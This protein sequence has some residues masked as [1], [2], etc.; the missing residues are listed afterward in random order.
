MKILVIPATNSADGLNR[1]L[2][3]YAAKLLEGGLLS[4][5]LPSDNRVEIEFVD[6][7]DYEMPIY[8]VKREQADGVPLAGQRLFEKIGSA[9]AII[10]SFAEYNGSYTSAW[11]NIH[12][13]MSRIDM[14]IYQGRKVAMFAA[15]PGPRG[16]AGVLGGAIA[17]APFFGAELVGSLG[18]PT[19]HENVDAE[20]GE[21]SNSDL[22]AEFEK[23]LAQLV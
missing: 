5:R 7:N 18:I 2:V 22:R 8:S 4:D 15:S 19:F 12:D 3:G 23:V 21:I 14:A 6:I 9:D 20:T 13:W 16:G 1:Q 17:T 11:K 10:M